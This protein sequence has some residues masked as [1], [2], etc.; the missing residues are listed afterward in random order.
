MTI[1]NIKQIISQGESMQVEFKAALF[2]LPRSIY[3]TICAFL[4]RKGGTILLGVE[5]NGNITGVNDESIARQ[6]D[7]IAKDMNNPKI[8][9]PTSYLST[10]VYQIDGKSIIYIYVPESSQAHCFNSVYYDRNQDGDFRILNQ[11]QDTSLFIRKQD[12][13][14]ENKVFPYLNM[15]DFD[16]AQ[17]ELVRKIAGLNRDKHPWAT[18]TNEEILVSAR[19]RQKDQHT[20]KEGY[21]L[22][23]ALLFGKENTLASVLPHYKTDALCRKVN[24]SLYDDRDDIRCNL[25]QAY[26]RL[27]NF[28]HKHLSE[29][30]YIEGHQRISLREMIFREVVANLL[31]HREFSSA[32][33]ATLTIYQDVVIAEN[34]NKPYVMGEIEI[35]NL[36][37][38]PKNPAIANF[39]KQL[40]WVEELGS[41]IKNMFKYCPLYVA[42]SLPVIKDDDVFRITIQHNSD[43]DTANS[44]DDTVNSD[45]DT[46]NSDDDTVNSLSAK[47]LLLEVISNNE[48][49]RTPEL[50][51]KINKSLSTTKRYIK[52]LSNKIE[53]RGSSKT[54]GYYARGTH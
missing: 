22:A 28:I 3:E 4:N 5:D 48:G 35:T 51:E 40:G 6:L 33:P 41:G 7:T 14:T 31:I 26:Y 32:Y 43:D 50:A 13:Y 2:D 36:K 34:W 23:A 52:E 39:F 25:M 44:D 24:T 1:D 42:G 9:F 11:H 27:M 16:D 53:F 20:G 46:V 8:I 30:P 47:D 29:K 17:F 12:S 18:M 54:G 49:L 15:S 45:D 19:L 38:H 37:P 10:E 21:T